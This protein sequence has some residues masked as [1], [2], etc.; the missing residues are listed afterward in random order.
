MNTFPQI[1][2]SSRLPYNVHPF[3]RKYNQRTPENSLFSG[4][5]RLCFQEKGTSLQKGRFSPQLDI[6]I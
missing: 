3:R 5:I 2:I 1:V 4:K 6:F